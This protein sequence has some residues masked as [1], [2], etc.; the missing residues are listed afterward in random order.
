MN[1]RLTCALSGVLLLATLCQRS[2]D[3][4]SPVSMT[5]SD[6]HASLTHSHIDH[7]SLRSPAE[8]LWSIGTGWQDGW[9]DS[10]V[11]AHPHA[12]RRIGPWLVLDLSLIH[13]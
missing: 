7:S 8:G 4:R 1:T 9:P 2:S 11:H 12:A 13:I 3:A 5:F 10:W 6:G